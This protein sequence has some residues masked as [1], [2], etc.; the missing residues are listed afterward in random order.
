MS[1]SVASPDREAERGQ[2]K[3]E[4]FSPANI[5]GKRSGNC[6]GVL[7][8]HRQRPPVFLCI[9]PR[10]RYNQGAALGRPRFSPEKT[11]V[12][13]PGKQKLSLFAEEDLQ[14]TIRRFPRHL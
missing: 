9:P 13:A 14:V 4:I 6:D 12:V 3:T 8:K 2:H 1:E 11:I 7:G 5:L 10:Q